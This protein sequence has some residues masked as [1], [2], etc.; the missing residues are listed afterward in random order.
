MH[1]VRFSSLAIV[2]QP[3][4]FA[5]TK[6]WKS[7]YNDPQSPRGVIDGLHVGLFPKLEG[8]HLVEDWSGDD[9][10]VYWLRRY[11]W[12]AGIQLGMRAMAAASISHK[13]SST[14]LTP[15]AHEK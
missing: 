9:A 14:R 11:G 8:L 2:C 4:D 7:K 6:K 12:F 3:I 13:S 5:T 1:A 15:A 10:V